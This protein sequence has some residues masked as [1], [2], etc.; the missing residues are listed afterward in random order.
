MYQTFLI[1][2]EKYWPDWNFILFWP[3]VAVSALLAVS[4]Q[5]NLAETANMVEIEQRQEATKKN[6]IR[7]TLFLYYEESLVHIMKCE[8]KPT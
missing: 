3:D 1:I 4:V 6:S 2:W 5:K 8:F 7:P